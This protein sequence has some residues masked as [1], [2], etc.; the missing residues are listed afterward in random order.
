MNE[1]WIELDDIEALAIAQGKG[2]E[3]EIYLPSIEKWEKW[4]GI[5]WAVYRN[6]RG[7][8]APKKVTVTSEC[9]RHRQHH[10]LSWG[11]G[12][13]TEYWQ[14]FPAGDITGEVEE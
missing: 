14:R 7:R 1:E 5:T 12:V 13:N 3:I 4:T 9:W 10:G 2:W 6:Y 11:G 8:S